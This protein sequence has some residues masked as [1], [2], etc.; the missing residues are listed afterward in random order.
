MSIIKR[1]S[2]CL[3]D[4][5]L[6]QSATNCSELIS[7]CNLLSIFDARGYVSDDHYKHQR[8]YSD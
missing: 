4:R 5:D 2:I 6:F 3:N 8:T 1:Q 7:L